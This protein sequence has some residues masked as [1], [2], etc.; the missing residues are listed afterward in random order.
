MQVG[1]S[2]HYYHPIVALSSFT[3]VAVVSHVIFYKIFMHGMV[4]GA[5]KHLLINSNVLMLCNMIA[6][7]GLI[8][9][10]MK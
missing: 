7:G 8:Y 9:C 6:G 10:V 2:K 5:S 3:G 1:G 4:D